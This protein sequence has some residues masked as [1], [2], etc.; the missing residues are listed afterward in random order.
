MR[1]TNDPVSRLRAFAVAHRQTPTVQDRERLRV[2]A[3]ERAGRTAPANSGQWWRIENADGERA[4]L[5]IDDYIG[6]WGVDARDFTAQLNAISAPNIDLMI[7]SPGGDVWDGYA[8]HNALVAHPAAVTAHI[9]GLAASAASFVAMAG[10]ERIAY[11]PSQMMIHDAS[12]FVDIFGSF[13][14]A[15]I[16]NIVGELEQVST[17]LGQVSDTIAGVYANRAGGDAADWRALMQ[18]TT[19]YTPDGAK[20][21]GLVDRIEEK[22]PAANPA[23]EPAPATPPADKTAR[24]GGLRASTARLR[25]R[26]A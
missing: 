10:D 16:A 13:N 15:D 25:V 7:N 4:T 18:A 5:Y 17:L 2:E 19:W 6:M 12:A 26:A 11:R 14:P 22:A 3:W 20:A 23:P 8:I 24:A 9:V 21:A 1:P